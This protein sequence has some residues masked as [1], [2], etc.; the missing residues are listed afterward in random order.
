MAFDLGKMTTGLVDSI[1]GTVRGMTLDELLTVMAAEEK[2]SEKRERVPLKEL[3]R[4]VFPE[5]VAP[6]T[7]RV[8]SGPAS[9]RARKTVRQLN[10]MTPTPAMAKASRLPDAVLTGSKANGFKL[11]AGDY[12]WRHY[13]HRRL[14]ARAKT[15]GAKLVDKSTP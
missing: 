1:L 2:L 4:Q 5:G 8:S 13:T 15:L 3:V 7:K 12:T 10:E 6:A 9:A 14:V 11:V